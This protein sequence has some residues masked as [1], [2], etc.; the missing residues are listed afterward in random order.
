MQGTALHTT[1]WTLFRNPPLWT[2]SG[3]VSHAEQHS[4]VPRGAAVL[5]SYPSVLARWAS[6]SKMAHVTRLQPHSAL[7]G[8]AVVVSSF[9][10][11]PYRGFLQMSGALSCQVVW[12]G[13]QDWISN[14]GGLGLSG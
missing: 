14:E 3:P 12:T 6:S 2:G 4:H 9:T 8:T 13:H 10:L 7:L 1:V 5:C 11:L